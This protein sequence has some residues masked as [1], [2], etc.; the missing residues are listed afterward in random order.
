MP[1]VP[2]GAVGRKMRRITCM[3][4]GDD[5][6]WCMNSNSGRFMKSAKPRENTLHAATKC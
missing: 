3:M 4:A 1:W 5:G 6:K 2:V